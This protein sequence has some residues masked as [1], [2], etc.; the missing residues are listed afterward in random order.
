MKNCTYII[1][2]IWYCRDNFIILKTFFIIHFKTIGINTVVKKCGKIIESR[3]KLQ[4]RL[5]TRYLYGRTKRYL[6]MI[7]NIRKFNHTCEWSKYVSNINFKLT[8]QT[9]DT[10][11]SA[12]Y[13]TSK[14]TIFYFYSLKYLDLCLEM[15]RYLR[16]WPTF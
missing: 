6:T 3:I 8:F 10:S 9:N 16:L 14:I 11:K 2:K 1:Y 5:N 13:S 12:I 7:L 15:D 4:H